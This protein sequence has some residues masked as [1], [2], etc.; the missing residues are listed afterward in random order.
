MR[1]GA[2]RIWDAKIGAFEA[3][4]VVLFLGAAFEV[5]LA[6]YAALERP[7]LGMLSYALGVCAMGAAVMGITAGVLWHTLRRQ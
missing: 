5:S 3:V 7:D 4:N 1:L 6:I 2:S